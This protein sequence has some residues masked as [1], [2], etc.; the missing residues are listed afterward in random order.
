M[1]L[2][3]PDFEKMEAHLKENAVKYFNLKLEVFPLIVY[4]E[5]GIEHSIY[6]AP[7]KEVTFYPEL[8]FEHAESLKKD[9]GFW[10]VIACKIGSSNITVLERDPKVKNS[11]IDSYLNFPGVIS[12]VAPDGNMYY[13][14]KHAPGVE[15][16]ER[17]DLGIKVLSDD[18]I[19][20]LPPSYI[21]RTL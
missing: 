9:Y 21:I 18:D 20:Y 5:G 8:F 6:A 11:E 12:S 3:Y 17:E 13:F 16:I 10:S 2:A 15:A 19:V 7:W 1:N 14:F 4:I